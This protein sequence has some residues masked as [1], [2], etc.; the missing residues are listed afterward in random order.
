VTEPLVLRSPSQ[1][2]EEG[3]EENFV[4]VALPVPLR[5]TFTYRVPD[6]M[7]LTPGMRVAVPFSG[8]KLAGIV[9]G[10]T[11]RPPPEVKR[12]LKV[13][14][15]LEAEP[16]FPAELLAFLLEAADYYLHPVGEVMRAAAPVMP[17]DAVE[18]LRK[19]GAFDDG[20]EIEGA[21]LATRRTLRLTVVEEASVPERLGT[22]QRQLWAR[23]SEVRSLRLSDLQG[24]SGARTVARALEKK[25]IITIEECD[26]ASDPFF[27]AEVERE[28]ALTPNEEQAEAID[29]L[30]TALSTDAPSGFLLHGVTGSGKTEVYLQLVAEA[31]ERG[32]GVL[33]LVPEIALT[34]QLVARF[35]ARFGEGIAVLHS[36]LKDRQRHEAWRGL[37]AGRLR[38]AIGARSA[39]FAPVP[40]LGVVI[41]DEEHDASFKQEEGFRYHGRDMALLRAHR[42]GAICVLGSAT[43][44]MESV[45]LTEQGKLTRIRLTQRAQF[46]AMPTVEVLDL[47]RHPGDGPSG[48]PL[49]TGPLHRA[50]EQCLEAKGQAILF[51]NRR[52][53]SPTLRCRACSEICA[54]P[55]CSVSLTEHRKAGVLRC[56]Y[57]DFASGDTRLCLN[58]GA[59]ELEPI[60]VGTERVQEALS[61]ALPEA[62]VGRL[63]RDTA[64]GAGVEEVLDRM[65]RRELDVLVGTQMVTKGH[66]LPGVTL[67][68]ILLADQ[69]L[70][71]PDFRAA[72]RTFQLL[73]QV[74]GRAGR[75]DTP[76]RVILQT[77]QPDHPAIRL[78]TTHDFDA[79]YRS[80]AVNRKELNYTPYARLIALR[81]DGADESATQQL[82]RRLAKVALA[83]EPVRAGRVEVLGPAA[84]PIARLR[85]RY[86]FRMLLR[87]AARPDLRAVALALAACL[88][89]GIAPARAHIDVDPVGM[90]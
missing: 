7:S 14:G 55:S 8:R 51:L 42:A 67:V 17:R 9:L 59:R 75:G 6:G 68:G 62:R 88:D 23:V 25:G 33:V 90:L 77:Y 79:F 50:L 37:R 4:S 82:I 20:R 26:V 58:C 16:V 49:L 56:H 72:E 12:I 47:K 34:P 76:G 38:L 64:A 31:L 30:K 81:V 18:G 54:C 46:Q 87:G 41:V 63:D 85:G 28:A 71:F 32:K 65:R 74:S 10:P 44:S 35:R 69:S 45:F 53:F 24:F 22:R 66:D 36:G 40:E 11:E 39:L 21:R 60:G 19:A 57:C 1:D 61:L 78:A 13:S 89:Q 43:P 80:E 15:V 84:A 48:H 70:A 52:G 73:A 2:D 3:T 29:T 83:T 86:R 5:R 27:S